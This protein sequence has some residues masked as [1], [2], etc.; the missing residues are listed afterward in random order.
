MGT[1]SLVGTLRVQAAPAAP[2]TV[3]GTIVTPLACALV[4]RWPGGGLVWSRPAAVLVEREGRVRRI[5][6]VD[7]T[8]LV[9]AGLLGLGL[10]LAIA[11]LVQSMRRKEASL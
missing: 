11:S 8:R 7:V 2:V 9:Q 6:I 5:P 3:G 1:R 4:V 10:A